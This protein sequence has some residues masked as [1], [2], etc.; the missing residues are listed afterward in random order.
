MNLSETYSIEIE[1]KDGTVL[2]DPDDFNPDE[3]VRVSFIPNI[4]IFQRHDIIF[5][6]FK[7]IKKFG[8]NFLKLSKGQ[9]EYIYC[10]VT[11][12]FRFYLRCSS[13]QTIITDKDYEMY[14]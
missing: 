2:K 1:L 5:S 13:G 9:K 6:G 7:F 3:V 4:P 12:K 8:R 10:V 14:L 11:D